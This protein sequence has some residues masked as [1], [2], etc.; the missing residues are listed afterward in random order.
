MLTA[1]IEDWVVSETRD[2]S[3]LDIIEIFVEDR[4]VSGWDLGEELATFIEET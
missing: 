2:F 3:F 1:E 4:S